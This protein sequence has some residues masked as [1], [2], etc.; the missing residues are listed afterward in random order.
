MPIR[1]RWKLGDHLVVCDRTGFTRYA[2]Q[3]RK[4]WNG[5][6]TWTRAWFP[7]QP[8]DLVRGLK[9]DLFVEDPRPRGVSEF[10]GPLTSE[11]DGNHAAGATTL[12]VTSSARFTAGDRILIGLDNKQMFSTRVQTVPTATSLTL[13]FALPWSASSGAAIINTS[14]VAR[15]DIG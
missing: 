7:R 15:S 11:L 9:D 1:R 5:L 2:S 14:A 12:A 6:R 3:T 10:T 8:Q 4:E 13:V